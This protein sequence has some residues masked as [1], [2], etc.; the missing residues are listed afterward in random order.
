MSEQPVRPFTT[1]TDP[2]AGARPDVPLEKRVSD[3]EDIAALN[4]MISVYTS[5][6]DPYDADG[7]ASLFS[8]DGVWVSA[9]Y[10]AKEGRDAIREFIAGISDEIIWACHHVTN[11][12]VQIS[13]D[14][15]SATGRWYLLVMEDVRNADG[16]VDGYLA[17]A[18]YNNTFVK[19]DGRWY[20]QR[21][22]PTTKSEKVLHGGWNQGG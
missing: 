19:Q 5:Y 16:T 22:N 3:L 9:H 20:L 17:M 13:E 1:A 14:G 11:S 8:E 15:Q 21:C 10:G 12:D 2:F 6:C 18:D 7:F 4:R